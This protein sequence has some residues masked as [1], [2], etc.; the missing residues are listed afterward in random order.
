VRAGHLDRERSLNFILWGSGF[1]HGEGGIQVR[2][3]RS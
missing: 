1:D 3:A 2:P